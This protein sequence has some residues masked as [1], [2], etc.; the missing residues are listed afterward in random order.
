MAPLPQGDVTFLFTDIEGS[1][2]HLRRLGSAY[3]G[4]LERHRDLLT[5]AAERNAGRVFGSEGDALFIVFAEPLDA[6]A[7]AIDAQRSLAAE[8]WPGE[9]L[10]VRMG[11]HAG[12]AALVGGDYVGLALHEVARV[13]AAGHGG[14]VLISEV[15]AERLQPVLPDGVALRD[16]G[17]HRLKDLPRPEHLFQVVAPGL[18]TEFP[19]IRTLGPET[20][21]PAQLTSF[22]DRPEVAVAVELLARTRLLTVTGPGGT[23][24]SRLALEVAGAAEPGYPNGVAF[25]AL[26]TIR[27]P[28]LIAPAILAG[29]GVVDSSGRPPVVTLT[30]VLRERRLL[31][32]LDNFEQVIDGA[33]IVTDLLSACPGLVIIVTSRIPL[34]VAGEQELPLSPLGLPA[35]GAAAS[36]A[37]VAGAAAGRL[38][39]ERAMAVDPGFRLTGANAPLVAD[40]VARLDGLP[41]AVELAAARTRVL[42]LEAL[43]SRLDAA[44]GVLVGGGRDR[45]A[46]QQT[47]RGAIDWSYQLLE[48]A[49]ARL[50]GRCAVFEGAGA[51]PE[52]ETICGPAAELGEEPLEGC[53]SL[54]EKSLLRTVPGQSTEP[55]FGMLQTIREYATER[56]A[57]M[58]E[59]DLLRRRHALA[60]LAL[61][62]ASAPQLTGAGA[63]ALLDRL[64]TDHDN[65]RAAL[66]WAV[67]QRE[68]ELALRLLA[69]LWRFWQL[70]GHI[71]EGSRRAET[72]LHLPGNENAPALLRARALGAAGGIA[73]WRGAWADAYRYYADAASVAR[74]ADDR[75]ALAEA[76]Y[77]LGFS[78]DAT[79][80][81]Q[82][83][84]YRAGRPYFLEALRLYEAV[85]DVRGVANC[86][87]A[88]GL[89]GAL[90]G[91]FAAARRHLAEAVRAYRSLDDQFGLG[92]ALHIGGDVALAEDDVA[93]ARSAFTEAMTIF[94]RAG[95]VGGI[96]YVLVD[97]AMLRRAEG[98]EAAYWRLGGATDRLRVNTGTDLITNPT[99]IMTWQAPSDPPSHAARQ[100]W[101]EGA[102]LSLEAAVEDALTP[103]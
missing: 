37:A 81:T 7:A 59:A 38:F 67:A 63:G 13:T 89:A 90:E 55:R 30:D 97:I 29:L 87:W 3:A 57:T 46:R 40:I 77:N 96:L 6:L 18:A 35:G 86:Q 52:V 17:L 26:E 95:D 39:V 69:A 48:P 15:A 42:P 11:V 84:R 103:R 27:D 45:S 9:P 53:A 93:A 33:P 2:R 44:L 16:L 4:V 43:Q 49:D 21:L 25:V 22:I 12:D 8:P 101:A 24:K 36:A 72:V 100:A 68:H 64:E 88:I 91:D 61:A 58:G 83:E 73:Y 102:S 94:R 82:E 54:V 31:L 99:M 79:V 1:T 75:A 76:L 62:E 78:P 23:G 92:W 34:R 98:D 56:L 60:Y 10:K 19:P 28:D 71:N 14:Q 20:R 47:L 70:R 66:D 80:R 74:A 41:L 51:L 5:A 50:F 32:V 65:L 85:A